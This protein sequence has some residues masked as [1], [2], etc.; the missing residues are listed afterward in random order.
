MPLVTLQTS[1]HLIIIE[2]A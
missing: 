2:L 1:Y